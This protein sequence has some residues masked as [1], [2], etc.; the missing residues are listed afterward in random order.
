MALT[1]SIQV[2]QSSLTPANITIVD[3][4]GGSDAAI[5]SR[6]VSFQDSQGRYVTTSG[7][8][9]APTF[10]TW[11]YGDSSKT[12]DIL[13]EDM[14]LFIT[15]LWLNSAG[16]TLY[17]FN[18]YYPLVKY[19]KNFAVYLGSLQANTPGILQDANYASNMATFWAYIQYSI[20]MIEEAADISNSQNLMN[21]ATYMR[22]NEQKYF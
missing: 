12:F 13:D 14:A 21:K 11:S 16:T 3:N 22:L 4:S 18:D 10:E 2:T 5:A 6:K 7:T 20:T 19:N 1:P 17:T 9:T 8:F 15:V